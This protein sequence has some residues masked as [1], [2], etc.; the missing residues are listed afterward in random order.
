MIK[1]IILT[2][3]FAFLLLGAMTQ[4]A[5]AVSVDIRHYDIYVVHDK[6]DSVFRINCLM[7]VYKNT[8]VD[9]IGM[10]I[11][12]FANLDSVIL[13]SSAGSFP[14]QSHLE[15]RIFKIIVPPKL[16]DDTLITVKFFYELPAPDI[17]DKFILEQNKVWYPQINNDLAT[18][19]VTVVV[20]PEYITISNGDL[21]SITDANGRKEYVWKSDTPANRFL[22]LIA[23]DNL[24]QTDIYKCPK[25]GTEIYL[26]AETVDKQSQEKIAKEAGSAMDYYSENIG[27]Y[28]YNRLSIIETPNRPGAEVGPGMIL[29]GPDVIGRF[30]DGN[31]EELGSMTAVEWIGNGLYLKLRGPGAFFLNL[32]LPQ[33]LKLLY[34][35]HDEGKQALQDSLQALLNIYKEVEGNLDEP[36]L[37]DIDLPRTEVKSKVL[38]GKGP[39]VCDLLRQ[40]IGNDKYYALLKKVYSDYKG[41]L[42]TFDDFEKELLK[43]DPDSTGYKRLQGLMT[44][45]GMPK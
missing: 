17:T 31:Y 34:L 44:K 24:Y 35:T 5:G 11:T 29:I 4:T 1:K 12:Q 3:V 20:Y 7:D 26:Y 13:S 2:I 14:A 23:Q 32:S 38:V 22:L 18:F 6:P 45:T 27:P 30:L 33:H 37:L 21:E 25:S 19:N 41:R 9:T 10:Y 42:F 15:W 40:T 43:I 16:R 8:D 28:L 36:A 39:Y